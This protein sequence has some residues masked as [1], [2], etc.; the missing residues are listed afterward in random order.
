MRRRGVHQQ[1]STVTLGASNWISC[2]IGRKL[3]YLTDLDA[4]A[5]MG[6][7]GAVGQQPSRAHVFRGR[8][9]LSTSRPPL[10][11]SM[12]EAMY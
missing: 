7:T 11:A 5:S 9:L 8:E 6:F 12:I 4:A 2:R 1:T 10:L 3:E